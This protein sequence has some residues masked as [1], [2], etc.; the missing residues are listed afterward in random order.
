MSELQNYS[1]M[2]RPYYTL[3]LTTKRSIQDVRERPIQMAYGYILMD[4]ITDR[5]P[6]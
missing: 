3:K 4:A 6:L 1:K 5:I 2:M